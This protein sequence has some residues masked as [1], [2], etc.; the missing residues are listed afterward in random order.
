VSKPVQHMIMGACGLSSVL[1]FLALDQQSY[2]FYTLMRF[3]VCCSSAGAAWNF[4]QRGEPV[5]ALP[6]V[7]TALLFN[8][9][10]PVHL[11]RSTWAGID[12]YGAIGFAVV[13][14]RLWLQSA[15]AD[16]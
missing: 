8:P 4:F 7:A 13:T 1:L 12:I 11:K 15:R 2:D 9:F 16:T 3:V 5:W 6:L 14:G 10:L